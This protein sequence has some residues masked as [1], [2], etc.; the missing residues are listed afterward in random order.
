M[1]ARFIDGPAEVTLR[2]PPPLQT[3]LAV[4]RDGQSVRLF[5][6][7]R[8]V[9]EGR[10]AGVDVDVPD[11][12]GLDEA[13]LASA[14][15]PGLADH[16]YPQCFACGP[17]RER[18]DG[19]RL[20]LGP[21]DGRPVFAAP[22]IPASSLPAEDGRVRPE[23]VWAAL[24]CSSGGGIPLIPG[25]S[26]VLLGRLAA[27]LRAPVAVGEPHVAVAWALGRDGRKIDMASA[28]F[29]SAGALKGVA[30]ARW[31]EVA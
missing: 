2:V 30:R 29:D 18:G 21:V 5:D 27:D 11:P 31:I 22:W 4:E 20:F 16:P 6:G 24:D 7:E 9:A 3:P 13:R 10:P 8:L 1:G 23:I 25:V 26:R 17:A 12:V 14:R 15:C 28:L 19:L